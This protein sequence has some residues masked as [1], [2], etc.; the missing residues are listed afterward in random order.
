[1]SNNFEMLNGLSVFSRK[2]GDTMKLSVVDG[3]ILC[4]N[5]C[6]FEQMTDWSDKGWSNSSDNWLDSGWNNSSYG[7]QDQGWSNGS[8]W[9]DSGWNNS[10]SWTDKGWSNSGGGCYITTACVEYAGLDDNCHELE[11]LRYYRDKLVDEDELFRNSVLDYYRKAPIIVQKIMID[12]DKNMILDFLYNELV[13]KTIS[14]LE[15]GNI[16]AAKSH[17]L[18]IFHKLENKYC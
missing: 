4:S 5:Q 14:L 13:K 9:I 11:V 1:M 3:V 15:S 10:G 8:A 17:Y 12:K 6:S 7:W 18:S 16:E 2:L